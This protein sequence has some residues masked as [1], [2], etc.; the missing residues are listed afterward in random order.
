MRECV[1]CRTAPRLQPHS[2]LRAPVTRLRHA[3]VSSQAAMGPDG[4]PMIWG[5]PVASLSGNIPRQPCLLGSLV[6][7]KINLWMGR[8]TQGRTHGRWRGG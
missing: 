3:C 7:Q 5:E 4:L 6:P 8:T 1:V 2:G